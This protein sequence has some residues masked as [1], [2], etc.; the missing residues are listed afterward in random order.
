MKRTAKMLIA[1]FKFA[2]QRSF[3]MIARTNHSRAACSWV[4]QGSQSWST[5]RKIHPMWTTCATSAT[6]KTSTS[7]TTTKDSRTWT[8]SKETVSF[9]LVTNTTKICIGLM[10]VK[11][12]LMR[13]CYFCR[14]CRRSRCEHRKIGTMSRL[15]RVRLTRNSSSKKN[16]VL[17]PRTKFQELIKLALNY[18]SCNLC[19]RICRRT[20]LQGY[21]VVN[22]SNRST[23]CS[24]KHFFR[25]TI[26]KLQNTLMTKTISKW[27]MACIFH[28]R[29]H[30]EHRL[31]TS[32]FASNSTPRRWTSPPKTHSIARTIH[33]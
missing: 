11:T 17:L 26:G 1:L 15:R 29:S 12:L 18:N 23:I 7:K 20:Q 19:E 16:Q 22:I 8:K 28:S 6:S 10:L 30:N 9:L 5:M 32:L 14:G 31:G 2:H 27:D 21:E 25:M 24:T 13:N 4:Q 3:P 33:S